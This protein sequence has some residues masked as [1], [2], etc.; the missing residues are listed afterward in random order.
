MPNNNS[1]L[2]DA[3]EL[4]EQL[5]AHL[6]L[7]NEAQRVITSSKKNVSG[8]RRY[9]IDEIV[10][11]SL[12]QVMQQ[13]LELATLFNEQI[14]Q[15][16]VYENPSCLA[17]LNEVFNYVSQVDFIKNMSSDKTFC[18]KHQQALEFFREL[19]SSEGAV[20][21]ADAA[22]AKLKVSLL[23]TRNKIKAKKLET[24]C[25]A[26]LKETPTFTDEALTSKL[27]EFQAGRHHPVDHTSEDHIWIGNRGMSVPFA[28]VDA[29]QA[30]DI[31]EIPLIPPL[32]SQV[33]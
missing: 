16:I 20:L 7:C 33:S 21:K 28:L 30:F 11:D 19:L 13:L 5:N 31:V 6:E 17:S 23:H 29:Q 26:V 15:S 3:A 22:L 24:A 9:D 10:I 2:L 18:G 14:E 12:R 4:K 8:Y 1:N 32:Q 25:Y 27:S